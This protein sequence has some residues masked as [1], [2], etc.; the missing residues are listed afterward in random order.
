MRRFR[1]TALDNQATNL[2]ANGEKP[3]AGQGFPFPGA[4]AG[5]QGGGRIPNVGTTVQGTARIAPDGGVVIQLSIHD[6]P[7]AVQA[8]RDEQPPPQ[9]VASQFQGTLSIPTGTTIVAGEIETEADQGPSR[10]V[11]LVSAD[12]LQAPPE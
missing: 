9:E 5:R 1:M 8:N 10:I 7:A 2:Q 3:A 4:G 11:I 12:V 6:A